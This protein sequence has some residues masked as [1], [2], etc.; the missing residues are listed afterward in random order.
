MQPVKSRGSFE[1]LVVEE[2]CGDATG[3]DNVVDARGIDV[4][5]SKVEA[6][7]VVKKEACATCGKRVQS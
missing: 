2:T 7:P 4:A 1:G 6:T 3:G 5:V